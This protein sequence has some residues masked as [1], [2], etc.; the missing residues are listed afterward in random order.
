MVVTA[1]A[2]R[3]APWAHKCPGSRPLHDNAKSYLHITYPSTTITWGCSHLFPLA[4][5]ASHRISVAHDE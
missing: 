2:P 3:V 4:I 1:H 5:I